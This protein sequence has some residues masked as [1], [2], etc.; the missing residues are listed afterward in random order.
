MSWIS[1]FLVSSIG[2]KLVMG[3][4]GIF[5]ISFLIVHCGINAC[6]F[7]NDGGVTFNK[8]A[9]FMGSNLLI[10]TMEIGLFL[11]ILLHIV[12]GLLIWASNAGKR[13]VAYA[14]FAG[15]ETHKWYSRSMGLLGTIILLFL[16]I[17]LADFW[18]PSRITGLE[19]VII[20]GEPHHNLYLKM[21]DRFKDLWVVILYVVGVI[22]LC[23][24]LMHGFSSAF[25]TLGFNHKKYEPFIKS[26]GFFFSIIISILFALMPISMF[27]GWVN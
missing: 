8:A 15:N 22:S 5:L 11:G 16:V 6:I 10:R 23:Y 12:Q 18:V 13:S 24:H 26:T 1:N 7:V 3:I 4:T 27:F 9:H 2:K 25:Q 17:H 14:K 20:D 21:Q 19:E